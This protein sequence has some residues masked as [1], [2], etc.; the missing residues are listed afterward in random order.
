MGKEVIIMKEFFNPEQARFLYPEITPVY[1]AA[2][3]GE[4]W[5]EVTKC[6]DDAEVKRCIGGF[7]ALAVSE[8]CEMCGNCQTRSAYETEELISRFE[9][10]AKTRPTAW[11]LEGG[12]QGITLAAVA[13]VKTPLEIAKERYP[14]NQRMENWITTTLG[15]DKVIWLDE[16]FADKSKKSSGNLSNFGTMCKG[17]AK[18]LNNSTIAFRTITDQM[19]AA[20]KRDFPFTAEVFKKEIEVPDRRDFVSIQS[21]PPY[22]SFIRGCG[23]W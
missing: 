23:N 10:I 5:F 4:P 8:I 18:N 15:S 2:F 9:Y 3:A 17:F 21:V 12:E 16:V 1:Q 14:D 22:P 11:Y 20:A 6:A 13:W 7:S 19:L